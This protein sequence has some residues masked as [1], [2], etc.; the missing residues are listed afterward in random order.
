MIQKAWESDSLD[1]TQSSLVRVLED[2]ARR[3]RNGDPVLDESVIADH[4]HLMPELGEMLAAM[5]SAETARQLAS[6][7]ESPSASTNGW[8]NPSSERLGRLERDLFRGYELGEIIG[9]GATGVVYRAVQTST[10]REVAI[11]VLL[12]G[13]FENNDEES[14]FE[15]EAHILAQLKHPNI[16]TVYDTGWSSG[17][18]FLVMDHIRGQQLDQ[19]LRTRKPT[20]REKLALFAAIAETVNAAHLRGIIHRDLKPSNIRI[21]ETGQPHLLDFGLAKVLDAVGDAMSGDVAPAYAHSM[22]MTGQF[23]GSLPW[24]S[25]E[26]AEGAPHK[27]DIRTDVY[28][29]GVMLY[30]ALAGHFPYSVMG[31]IRDVI[32]RILTAPPPRLRPTHPD[33]DDDLDTIL[34]TCLTKERERRYQS[35]A[36]LA[37]DLRRHLADE[38]IAAKRDSSWY[39]LRKTL[40]RHRVAFG[41]VAGVGLLSVTYAATVSVLYSQ[42]KREAQRAR[43]TQSFLQDTLFQ[44]SSHRLGSGATLAQ[45]LD[46]AAKRLPEEFGA[47]PEIEAALQHTVGAA[48]ESIWQKETGIEHLVRAVELSRRVHGLD[49]PE[50]LRSMVLLGMVMAETKR[51]ESISVLREA[52]AANIRLHGKQHPLVAENLAELAFSL[53]AAAQPP[54]WAEAEKVYA[55]SLAM[56]HQTV[57]PEHPDLARALMGFASM[58]RGRSRAAV[59]EGQLREACDMSKRLLGDVHQFTLEC[60]LGLS[61]V[62]VDLGRL[63]ESQEILNDLRPRAERQFGA[64]M[65]P[66]VLR[67]TAFVQMARLQYEGAERTLFEIQASVCERLA[68]EHPEKSSELIELASTLRAKAGRR[69]A[70]DTY[71]ESLKATQALAPD[72]M[73]SARTLLALGTIRYRQELFS[74]AETLLRQ[75]L[76]NLDE[77]RNREYSLRTRATRM[78][79]TSLQMLGRPDE[80]EQVLRQTLDI[81]K[82]SLGSQSGLTQVVTSDLRLLYDRSGRAADAASLPLPAFR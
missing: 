28:S 4:P 1:H 67:R 60:Q 75:C 66:M 57:G 56:F 61:D 49:H 47:Q 40:R 59:A 71:L 29:L 43:L 77:A 26:Q 3:R 42:S 80:S 23:V 62:L 35:A 31:N 5:S 12:Q 58:N 27:I 39:V 44:A 55:E 41:V 51:P 70:D 50:T 25:P 7:R 33:V 10:G 73:E 64:S 2:V 32:D 15:R 11:K 9:R 21:D 14:R 68:R 17:R 8:N 46:V 6:E 24:A 74:H 13:T 37:Q 81:L 82:D 52:L 63:D 16:V 19:W 45:V 18:Y 20:L 72:P 79:A 34:Q 53:W 78:L 65:M 76:L 38:P 48:Y 36:E 54:Q 22:T 69:G 30:H